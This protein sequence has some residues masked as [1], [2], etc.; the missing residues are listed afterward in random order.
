MRLP[1]L[2]RTNDKPFE[3]QRYRGL[4][5]AVKHIIGRGYSGGRSPV[6]SLSTY[7]SATKK[8][9]GTCKWCL[10]PVA[11]RNGR[12]RMWHKSCYDNWFIIGRGSRARMDG[13][14]VMRPRPEWTG[15]DYQD[16]I[17]NC[18]YPGYCLH[19]HYKTCD[20]SCAACGQPTPAYQLELDHIMAIRVA[21]RIHESLYVRVFT[22]DNLWWICKP[23][24][25][26]KTKFDRA[27]MRALDNPVTAEEETAPL[28]V[29]P[30]KAATPPPIPLFDWADGQ[31]SEEQ[32][33]GKNDQ[34]E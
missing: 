26:A 8:A 18:K 34:S 14:L 2:F 13:S 20:E 27:F 28:V 21:E 5:G 19:W 16:A 7:G 32:N 22:P 10:L 24:H 17:D 12:L 9:W 3:Q 1:R 30:K 15:D 31:Q 33:G 23:C 4:R 29:K 6:R 25:R 11:R